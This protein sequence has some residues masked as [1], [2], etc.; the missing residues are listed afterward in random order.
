M[1]ARFRPLLS[2]TAPRSPEALSLAGGW[3]WFDRVEVLER[4]T[5][6]QVIAAVDLPDDVRL[7]LTTPRPPVV[8]LTMDRPRVMGILNVTPDSFS[9]GGSFLGREVA[10]AHGRAMVAAGAEIVDVGGESTRPGAGEVPAEVEISRTRGVVAALSR[11]GPVSI[12]TR[13][14]SVARAAF[15]AGADLLNDVSALRHDPEMAPM[16]ARARRPVCLMHAQG[17]PGTM[18][19]D[20]RYEDV[21]LDIYDFLEERM[22]FAEA[23]GIP[24]SQILLDV[25]IG[26]GKTVG[27][28]L[29]LLRGL[30]LFHGLGCTLLLGASRKRFIGTIGGA[31]LPA[32]RVPVSLAVALAGVAQGVQILR[33]H[34]VEPTVQAL[35]LWRAV[36]QDAPDASWAGAGATGADTGQAG[37]VKG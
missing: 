4:G 15:D 3:C 14:A 8:G 1:V 26:F 10:Q 9:D 35:R 12:D 37:E 18:Q 33:V 31:E 30:G 20:P 19:D 16:A 34:D 2:C 11:L 36:T 13:K 22:G 21:L 24:R 28:N 17:D 23:Q 27:H 5:P 32:A 25:G 6:P 7:R 29:A